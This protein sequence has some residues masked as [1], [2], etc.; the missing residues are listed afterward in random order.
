MI[1]DT[2]DAA[3]TLG[4]AVGRLELKQAAANRG[5]PSDPIG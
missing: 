1:K 3:G 2:F 5:Q 4:L